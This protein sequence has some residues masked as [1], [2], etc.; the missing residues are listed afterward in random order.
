MRKSI[1]IKSRSCCRREKERVVNEVRFCEYT[2]LTP[3]QR[4]GCYQQVARNSGSRAR[5]CL[6]S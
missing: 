3:E 5:E 6:Y 1:P 4:S 2:A